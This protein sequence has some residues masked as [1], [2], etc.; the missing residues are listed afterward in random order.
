MRASRINFEAS[1]YLKMEFCRKTSD[2]LQYK[3]LAKLTI[4][5]PSTENNFNGKFPHLITASSQFS[6]LFTAWGNTLYCYDY[7]KIESQYIE[8]V[9]V[10]I[11][12]NQ[13]LFTVGLA[14]QIEYIS[15]S[16]SS[17]IIA[18]VT[19]DKCFI[20]SI[21]TLLANKKIGQ[22]ISIDLASDLLSLEWSQ[23]ANTN[24]SLLITTINDIY[25][26][27]SSSNTI[28][29]I[30]Q[31]QDI[32]AASWRIGNDKQYFIAYNNSIAIYEGKLR[33][34]ET[35]THV[36]RPENKYGKHIRLYRIFL[37]FTI[38]PHTIS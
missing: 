27:N 1:D 3:S 4:K 17:K 30:H 24:E 21:N 31:T 6:L 20:N 19:K 36:I 22:T 33:I 38:M 35:K 5:D 11:D 15:L 14:E 26:Y 2:V 23:P 37:Y 13:A 10:I 29:H 8:D 12:K 9:T 16:A 18:I 32:S 34:A 25:I 7:S 28:E